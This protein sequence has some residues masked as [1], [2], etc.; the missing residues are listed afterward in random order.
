MHHRKILGFS[1]TEVL[2][3]TA[4]ISISL[5]PALNALNGNTLLFNQ[6]KNSSDFHN[7]RVSYMETILSM[8]YRE[9]YRH[10]ADINSRSNKSN[11]SDPIQQLSVYIGFHDLDNI[12]TDDDTETIDDDNLDGDSNPFTNN[13]TP[14]NT[15][16]IKV[17]LDNDP[18]ELI[19]L[20]TNPYLT[21]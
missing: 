9:L 16:W 12:D 8:P 21:Y 1:Y 5:V 14:I 15:L 6:L 13:T 17:V 4:L 3:A 20:V 10:A 11:L 7:Q 18:E 2:I 19:T